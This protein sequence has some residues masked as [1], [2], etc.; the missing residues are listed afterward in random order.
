M[1]KVFFYALAILAEVKWLK[2]FY[3]I[4]LVIN[5]RYSVLA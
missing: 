5:S 1:K 4:W 2:G 3:D